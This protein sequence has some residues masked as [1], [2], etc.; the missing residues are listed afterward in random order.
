M[1]N[2]K[3]ILRLSHSG[4]ILMIEQIWDSINPSDIDMKEEHKKELDKRL[5]R[6]QKGNTRFHS[7]DDIKQDLSSW[8]T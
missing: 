3:E 2:I 5:E 1:T 7:W 4:R 8:C 6:Y